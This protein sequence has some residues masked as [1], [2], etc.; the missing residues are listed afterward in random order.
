LNYDEQYEKHKA[1]FG[2]EPEP[3]LVAYAGRLPENATVLDIGAGQGRNS[4][5]MAR[6]GIAVDALEPSGPGANELKRI[7]AEER[8]PIRHFSDSFENYAPTADHYS[9][10]LVFGLI[11]DLDWK[12]IGQ[13]QDRIST[14]TGRG[15]VIW[16]TGFTV[17]DPAYAK[18]CSGRVRTYLE[19]GQILQ[20]FSRYSALH[21]WEGMGP[22]HRH[23]DGPP[24]RHGMFEAVFERRS[25]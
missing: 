5:Y 1:V 12:A 7:A 14:W 17:L 20:L 23:G 13:L 24:E 11:P 8:L 2:N 19:P 16:I 4:A 25:T 9:G 15:S 22:E 10:I 21:H 6:R 18:Q 3:T